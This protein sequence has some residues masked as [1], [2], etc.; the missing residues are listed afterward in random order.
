MSSPSSSQATVYCPRCGTAN[1]IAARSCRACGA[2]LPTAEERDRDW[3]SRT[4][5]LP[6]QPAARDQPGARRFPDGPV[7]A[8]RPSRRRGPGGCVLGCLGL[9][10][11]FVVTA[12]AGAWLLIPLAREATLDGVRD[13][14]ATEVMRIGTL[15]VSPSGELVISEEDVNGQIRANIDQFDRFGPLGTPDFSIGPDGVTLDVDAFGQSTTYRG[16]V[17]VAD[18]RLVVTDP[19]VDGPAGR[20]LPADEIADFVEDLAGALQD[21]SGVI[22]TGVELRDGEMVFS[23][24][25]TGT[26]AAMDDA[27]APPRR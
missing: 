16:D 27:T 21:R 5:P 22:F 3:S 19:T 4:M 1:D 2:P 7:L 23:T 9:V 8:E 12:G 10:I 13:I 6:T 26:P 25:P 11:I 14:A 20:I 15:P 18:G 17:T 24:R